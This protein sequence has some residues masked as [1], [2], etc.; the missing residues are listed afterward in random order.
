MAKITR[1]GAPPAIITGT[2]DP[3]AV[4]GTLGQ[5]YVNTATNRMFGPKTV[6]G[7]GP[8]WSIVG[9][10]GQDGLP[11]SAGTGGGLVLPN[12]PLAG[13]ISAFE[14][15]QGI[16]VA[17]GA[18][19][20]Q[21]S[22]ISGNARHLTAAGAARPTFRAADLDS[23]PYV[24]GDGVANILGRINGAPYAGTTL[25]L[26]VIAR[27]RNIAANGRIANC[28]KAA[29]VA[30]ETLDT[31]SLKANATPNS[32]VWR[33]SATDLQAENI[34]VGVFRG[35][36]TWRMFCY[37]SGPVSGRAQDVVFSNFNDGNVDYGAAAAQPVWGYDRFSLFADNIAV[38]ANFAASDVRLFYIYNLL[39]GA[40][41][42]KA[43]MQYGVN[44]WRVPTA[45]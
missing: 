26:Y 29:T 40:H 34:G 23:L 1:A 9:I 6:A 42:V 32:I 16:G 2:V 35:R 13:A 33:R 25:T 10:P 7:W 28:S 20:P 24:E 8:G 43:M 41:L 3:T 39:H 44:K 37:Q 36:G 27:A 22:D 12:I 19:V 38:P 31:V 14:A 17:D 21:W 45:I 4:T 15:D 11:G 18:P 30:G 5:F